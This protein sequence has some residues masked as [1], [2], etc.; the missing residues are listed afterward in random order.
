MIARGLGGREQAGP[1][2]SLLGYFV[3]FL[4]F[5]TDECDRAGRPG[6][7]E[8]DDLGGPFVE[9]ARGLIGSSDKKGP[10]ESPKN[11]F[12]CRGPFYSFSPSL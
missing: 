1:S 12:H 8:T 2:G 3:S 5:A 9:E 11:R 4:F 7:S 6:R 10:T